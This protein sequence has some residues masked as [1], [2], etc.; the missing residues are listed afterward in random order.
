ML[1]TR[2]TFAK[3]ILLGIFCIISIYLFSQASKPLHQLHQVK[4]VEDG[5]FI[6]PQEVIDKD[7]SMAPI[8]E[9]MRGC[10]ILEPRLHS[11]ADIESQYPLAFSIL[12]H[13]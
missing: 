8:D 1:C 11:V 6:C 4:N 13:R 10:N 9:R 12:A 3:I 2:K 5:D 7:K